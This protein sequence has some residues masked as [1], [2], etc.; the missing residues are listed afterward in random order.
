[1][2]ASSGP[3]HESKNDSHTAHQ[4]DGKNK[5]VMVRFEGVNQEIAGTRHDADPR[6]DVS[7]GQ[8]ILD[9]ASEKESPRSSDQGDGNV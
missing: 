9:Q 4:P 7:F 5:Q 3:D 6:S 8:F 1:M 2:G